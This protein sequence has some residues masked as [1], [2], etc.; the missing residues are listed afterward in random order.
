MASVS[1]SAVPE[2]Y[3]LYELR[4]GLLRLAA[5][6]ADG[7]FTLIVAGTATG[8]AVS[9]VRCSSAGTGKY[10]PF[11][12]DSAYQATITAF[13]EQVVA[14]LDSLADLAATW[15][16]VERKETWN[17]KLYVTVQ[18]GLPMSVRPEYSLPN[19]PACR[20]ATLTALVPER[21]AR[22]AR[23]GYRIPDASAVASLL[24]QQP[25]LGDVLRVAPAALAAYFPGATRTLAVE[26]DT[27]WGEGRRQQIPAVRGTGGA[28]CSRGSG[29]EAPGSPKP[30]RERVSGGRKRTGDA[31]PPWR[32]V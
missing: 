29:R 2:A 5:P 13:L 14:E 11:P 23:R 7:E 18:A 20:A 16:T 25:A 6:P 9:R 28:G 26:Q 15:R 17:A 19:Q 30:G 1:S 32:C 12:L 24:Q 8:I 27:L 22:L 4:S 3:R 21:V 31:P 10:P